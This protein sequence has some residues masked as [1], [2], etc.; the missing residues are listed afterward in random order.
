MRTR[1]LAT[2]LAV[3][4]LGMTVAGVL[5]YGAQR[6]FVL[7]EI[8]AALTAQLGYAR[9]AAD[10]G[11]VTSARDALQRIL[12]LTVA[13][14]DGGAVGI[15][16]G[17]AAYL[18]GVA[19]QLRPED[20]D[21]FIARVADEDGVRIDTYDG[22]D[23]PVRYLAVP[24]DVAG[25]SET[26]VYAVAV[27]IRPRLEGVDRAAVLYAAVSA[28]VLA[29]TG[30]L[31]WFI[32][33]RLLAPVRQLRATAQR[34]TVDALAERIPVEGRDDVSRLTETINSMLDRIGEGVG[35]QRALV[36]D[37]RHEL[38]APLAVVRGQLELLDPSDPADVDDSRRIAI[39]EVDRMARLI[40]DLARLVE[41]GLPGA[42]RTDV[43]SG[44]LVREVF[45]RARAIPGPTWSV[46]RVDAVPLSLDRDRI[47]EALLQLASN[48]ARH[49]PAG[50][51]VELSAVAD[52][53]TVRLIVRDH[54]PGVPADDR[55][56]IFERGERGR[57]A[58]GRDGD[59][60]GLAIVA[61]IARAHGGRARVDEAPGG[62]ASFE[63]ILP[64]AGEDRAR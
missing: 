35:Q 50:T 49:T 40:D 3:T 36:A 25:D 22:G 32:A 42:P 18:P 4:A 1:I 51:S 31:G 48:A 10:D 61:A 53:D 23:E 11:S 56:R 12:S 6:T 9:E 55:E 57:D 30:I 16:D 24:I 45:D 44:E 8:D 39:D 43:D 17:R 62:G 58:A 29:L 21:G 20:L 2:V 7:G 14:Q 54:G 63:L 37:L 41:S 13:P 26:A 34:I 38:R 59:G 27:A 60:L 64:R 47:L 28:G 15:V 19:E 5:S 52:P 46:G 33:G